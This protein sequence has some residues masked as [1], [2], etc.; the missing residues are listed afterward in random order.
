MRRAQQLRREGAYELVLALEHYAAIGLK[1]GDPVLEADLASEDRQN[2]LEASA[3]CF[4]GRP[5]AQ[6]E[7]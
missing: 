2:D 6:S 7:G 4:S 1:I 5:L 3:T